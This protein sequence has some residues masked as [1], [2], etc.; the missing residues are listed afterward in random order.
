M[1]RRSWIV[2]SM[3]IAALAGYYYISSLLSGLFFEV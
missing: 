2:S 3:M 1:N